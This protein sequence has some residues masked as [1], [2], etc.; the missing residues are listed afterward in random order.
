MKDM[1]PFLISSFWGSVEAVHMQHTLF[2]N[3]SCNNPMT[4]TNPMFYLFRYGNLRIS[5][6]TWKKFLRHFPVK[7]VSFGDG[8]SRQWLVFRFKFP[9]LCATFII[10]RRSVLNFNSNFTAKSRQLPVNRERS[11][12]SVR[13]QLYNWS[14]LTLLNTAENESCVLNR[15]K[16][17]PLC[18]RSR[19]PRKTKT[20]GTT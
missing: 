14:L 6:I 19:I 1:L 3:P 16:R 15:L 2:L 5:S 11:F 18:L 13:Q 8:P 17:K 20:Q 10:Q 4:L 7:I 12:I 9:P